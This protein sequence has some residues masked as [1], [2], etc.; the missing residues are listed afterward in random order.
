MKRNNKGFDCGVAIMLINAV[1][2]LVLSMAWLY[3]KDNILT[4][5]IWLISAIIWSVG[6]AIRFRNN[7]M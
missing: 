7:L 3:N 6:A 5:T 1:L 2:N 4:A